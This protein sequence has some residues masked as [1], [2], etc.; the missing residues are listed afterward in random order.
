M[1]ASPGLVDPDTLL[2]MLRKRR[3]TRQFTSQ[4]VPTESLRRI[5]EAG[6]WATSGGNRYPHRFLVVRD[7][8]RISL[9]RAASP[10]M[11]W[12]PPALIITMLEMREAKADLMNVDPFTASYIDVGTAAMSMIT[13]LQSLG[14]GACPVTSF[15]RSAVSAML[16]LPEYLS[17][18]FILILGYPRPVKR[19][20]NPNAPKP[21]TVRDLTFWEIVG[22]HDPEQQ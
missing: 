4:P 19:T 8:Q 20:I 13:M 7:P 17:P 3:V 22:V 10:G 14:L 21:L 9:V 15:S 16:E 11:L 2:G 12:E 5:V 6:R 18:E 1:I